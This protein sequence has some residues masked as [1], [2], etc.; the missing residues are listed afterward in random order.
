MGDQIMDCIPKCKIH[1][2]LLVEKD[3]PGIKLPRTARGFPARWKGNLPTATANADIHV[4]VS[5]SANKTASL[6]HIDVV[7]NQQLCIRR[8]RHNSRAERSAERRHLRS[9]KR[10][11]DYRNRLLLDNNSTRYV[12]ARLCRY[13]QRESEHQ[14]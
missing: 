1:E 2:T 13:R 6:N 8:L 9:E 11:D 7:A 5:S 10:I 14:S 4:D 3:G 12:V